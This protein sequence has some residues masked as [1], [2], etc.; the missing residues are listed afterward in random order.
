VAES[1][2]LYRT[3]AARITL[4]SQERVLLFSAQYPNLARDLANRAGQ[5]VIH[6]A[7]FKALRGLQHST[8]QYTNLHIA[9]T[10]FPAS[11]SSFDKAVIVNP[12]GR[13]FARAQLWSAYNSLVENGQVYL[14]GANDSGIKSLIA[15]A[16]ALFAS[17]NTL[18]Y[19]GGHRI[20]GAYKAISGT[21]YPARWGET[22]TQ[23][24][25]RELETPLGLLAIGT[26]P[27]VFSWQALDEGTKFLLKQEPLRTFADGADILD[28][29]C[30]TGV[31]GCALGKLANSVHLVDV[32]LLAVECARETIRLNDLAQARAYPSNVY[33]EVEDVRFDLIISNPPF[34]QGF[35]QT[36]DI[37]RQLIAQA[38]DYLKPGGRLVIVANAFLPYEPIM[39]QHL[40]NVQT[41]ARNNRYKVLM[42][43]N[44]VV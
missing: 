33:S 18:A 11:D 20:G 30:G 38:P 43:Q 42:G 8:N 1:E 40:T 2:I 21:P 4:N 5:V 25:Q 28:M 12:K 10:P 13:D 29:G 35:A 26:M 34:H 39:Q 37:T 16:G 7:D 17:P 15:D 36:Q 3:L 9:D 22:S 19:K 23:M 31:I 44:S 27:G 41:L 32:N 14:L 6:D 24:Q